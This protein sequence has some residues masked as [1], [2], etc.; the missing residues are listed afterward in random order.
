ML[1]TPFSSEVVL[2]IPWAEF[3]VYDLDNK[4]QRMLYEM[5]QSV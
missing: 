3:C 1:L 4:L 5:C 2:G